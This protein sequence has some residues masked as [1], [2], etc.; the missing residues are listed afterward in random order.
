VE[1]EHGKEERTERFSFVLGEEVL[2]VEYSVEGPIP[3]LVDMSE[4][5]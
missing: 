3:E 4:F 2:V 1:P 5:T